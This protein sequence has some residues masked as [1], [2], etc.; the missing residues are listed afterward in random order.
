MIRWMITLLA[1]LLC[2]VILIAGCMSVQPPASPPV[3]TPGQTTVPVT[4]QT[5]TPHSTILVTP[6]PLPIHADFEEYPDEGKVPL[7][8]TFLDTS[9]GTIASWD[10]DFGDG[11]SSTLQNPIHTYTFPGNYR[12]TL[13]IRGPGGTSRETEEIEVFS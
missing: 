11:T 2:A 10:W 6:P 3:Q 7:T 1:A 9:S 4:I 5:I 8:V 13:T 12:A